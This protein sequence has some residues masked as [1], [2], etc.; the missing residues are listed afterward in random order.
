M[1]NRS[2]RQGL[3][4]LGNL[5]PKIAPLPSNSAS[6][7]TRFGQNTETTGSGALVPVERNSTGRRL[8]ATTAVALPVALK[9]NSASLTDKALLATLPRP[10]ALRLV[11]RVRYEPDFEMLGYT[12][13]DGAPLDH[14]NKALAIV[15][16][17][18]RGSSGEMVVQ[19]LAKVRS[20]TAAREKGEDDAELSYV[21]MA[22]ML[23]EFPPDVIRDACQSWMKIEKWR[24]TLAEMRDYC[25]RRFRLRASIQYELRRAA[26]L[27]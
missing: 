6:T 21:T 22:S 9:G 17:A 18:C 25:W 14:I 15:D 24:P 19:E 12:L 11:S 2:E 1:E 4:P 13:T 10:V 23:T 20:V 5:V 26:A 16:E 3:T 27:A 7:Q 8:G